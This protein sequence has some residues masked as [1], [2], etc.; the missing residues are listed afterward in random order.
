MMWRSDLKEAVPT[1]IS[2]ISTHGPYDVRKRNE[3][4]PCV[5]DDYHHSDEWKLVTTRREA[6]RFDVHRGPRFASRPAAGFFEPAQRQ[7]IQL[8][9]NQSRNSGS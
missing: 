9:A 5:G 7:H 4:R 1:S 2:V 3:S 6:V 8:V